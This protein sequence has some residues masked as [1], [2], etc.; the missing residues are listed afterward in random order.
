MEKLFSF[1]FFLEEMLI[2]YKSGPLFEMSRQYFPLPSIIKNLSKLFLMQLVQFIIWFIQTLLAPSGDQQ[3]LIRHKTEKNIK[4][5]KIAKF[6]TYSI[7]KE[8]KIS[9]FI[10][11]VKIGLVK[12]RLLSS[13]FRKLQWWRERERLNVVLQ[14]SVNYTLP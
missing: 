6:L 3:V 11:P 8:D 13:T 4:C 9:Y 1:L 12:S 5:L 10:P 14:K 2:M 7:K